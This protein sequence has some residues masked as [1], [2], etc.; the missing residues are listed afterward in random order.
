M[1]C[2]RG[3]DSELAK[4]LVLAARDE[5]STL[6]QSQHE[7]VQAA[8]RRQLEKQLNTRLPKV[9]PGRGALVIFVFGQAGVGKTTTLL[10]L[11]ARLV[12]YEDR[13]VAIVNADTA[14]PAS[15]LQ[16]EFLAKPFDL[17]VE[18]VISSHPQALQSALATLADR[19]VIFVDTP[20]YSWRERAQILQLDALVKVAP[21][22]QSFLVLGSSIIVEELDQILQGFRPIGLDGL[23]FSKVDETELTG[24]I[25]T[26]S[27]QS[28]VPVA[29]ITT[30][31]R[32][33]DDIEPAS[34]ERLSALIFGGAGSAAGE[35]S[36]KRPVLRKQ[37]KQTSVT[38]LA[39]S[40]ATDSNIDEKGQIS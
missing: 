32:I 27:C 7:L 14:R 31:R 4:A 29:Y 21:R 5:L 23:V 2:D 3:L 39:D 17:V 19:D 26:L 9:I 20:G 11:A 38:T 18:T 33:P 28:P 34:P 13:R 16:I 40:D 37:K 15:Q 12:L 36:V 22:R 6:A 10:K 8:V 35:L 1:L 30:G 24:T 25:V